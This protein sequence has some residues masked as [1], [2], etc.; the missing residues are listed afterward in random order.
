MNISANGIRKIY[1]IQSENVFIANWQ[2]FDLVLSISSV[3]FLNFHRKQD[4]NYLHFALNASWSEPDYIFVVE[5][6]DG[7][8]LYF[9]YLFAVHATFNAMSL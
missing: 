3:I 9:I 5:K 7:I 6:K 2:I 8:N 4:L 1:F